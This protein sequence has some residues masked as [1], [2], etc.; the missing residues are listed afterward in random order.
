MFRLVCFVAISSLLT[1]AHDDALPADEPSVAEPTTLAIA[2]A[3]AAH[4]AVQLEALGE[5]SSSDANA[6]ILLV[7]VS[8]ATSVEVRGLLVEIE[9]GEASDRVYLP[10][11]LLQEL[12]RELQGFA[13]RDRAQDCSAQHMCMYGIARCRPSQTVKQAWCPGRYVRPGVEEGLMISTARHRFM[14]PSVDSTAIA[15]LFAAAIDK[16]QPDASAPR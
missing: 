9:D 6:R 5:V 16:L 1:V 10:E 12:Q 8:S 14:F 13:G 11:E 2:V 7:A 3:N 15:N 4:G